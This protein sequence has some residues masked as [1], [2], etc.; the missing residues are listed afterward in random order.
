MQVGH[1]HKE[2]FIG[3]PHFIRKYATTQIVYSLF[4]IYSTQIDI[5]SFVTNLTMESGHIVERGGDH[6]VMLVV[7]VN[8]CAEVKRTVCSSSAHRIQETFS[9]SVTSALSVR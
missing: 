5:V 9:Q 1:H 4:I 3:R 8:K 6:L 7:Q 2:S